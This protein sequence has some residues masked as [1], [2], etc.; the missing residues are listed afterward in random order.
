L[1]YGGQVAP[2]AL[3]ACSTKSA[4]SAFPALASVTKT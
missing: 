2:S 4:L 1:G 3:L